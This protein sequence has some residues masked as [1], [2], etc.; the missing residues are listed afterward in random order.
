MM[1][2]KRT[3]SRVGPSCD[4]GELLEV[5]KAEDGGGVEEMA[6]GGSGEE[7]GETLINLKR[8]NYK[9][10]KNESRHARRV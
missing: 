5:G 3:S 9:G 10:T 2:E 4:T 7:R 1:S 6:D 8:G